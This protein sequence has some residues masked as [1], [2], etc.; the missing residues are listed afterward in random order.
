MIETVR[1]EIR[2]LNL[3]QTHRIGDDDGIEALADDIATNGIHSRPIITTD[4]VILDGERVV[5]ALLLLGDEWVTVERV[6]HV[7]DAVALLTREGADKEPHIRRKTVHEKMMLGDQLILFDQSRAAHRRSEAAIRGHRGGVPGSKHRHLGAIVAPA[8]GYSGT[9]Y[10]R[11]RIVWR[12]GYGEARQ[13]PEIRQ[14]A[15][16][17][18]DQIEKGNIGPH[19]ARVRIQQALEGRPADVSALEVID[20]DIPDD[21]PERKALVDKRDRLAG[22]HHR[23]RQRMESDAHR[24]TARFA[25]QLAT[26]G[27]TVAALVDGEYPITLLPDQNGEIASLK[28]N[29]TTAKRALNRLSRALQ[30]RE[31]PKGSKS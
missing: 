13:P 27:M 30:A 24:T 20:D 5:K 18:L 19:Y 7:E 4:G 16:Y 22:R 17:L 1:M 15:R 10:S 28:R 2:D 26:I 31:N 12:Y 3:A 11:I 6:D 23:T 9:T 8:L 25:D 29:L 14:L 21:D